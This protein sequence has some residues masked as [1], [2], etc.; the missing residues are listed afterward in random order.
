MKNLKVLIVE[1]EIDLANLIK[2]SIKELF[3]KVVIAKDGLEAIKKFDSF[4]PDII[5]SDI[6]MPNLNG[7]EMSKKIKEKYSETPIVILSAHSHKEM[8]L[9]AI[10]LGISKYFIKPFDIEEFIEYLKELSKKINKNKS[11][12]LKDNFIFDF[13][14]LSLYQNDI[15]VN[16]TKRERQFLALLIENKNS[17]VTTFDIKKTLWENEIVSDE[18]LRTFIKRLRAKT[19]KELIENVSSCGYMVLF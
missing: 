11:I 8:L 1:D 13:N 7:L 15:L 5:I 3:F 9:E 12:K 17:Y 2:S 10:D 6:M 14:N 16:L 19:S 18:R 4:K